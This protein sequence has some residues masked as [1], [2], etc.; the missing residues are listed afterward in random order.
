M[1]RPLFEIGEDVWLL[2]ATKEPRGAVVL[3]ILEVDHAQQHCHKTIGYDLTIPAG[4][5]FYGWCECMLRKRPPPESL[6]N[7]TEFIE[8]LRLMSEAT[9]GADHE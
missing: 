9:I 3:E 8:D 4:D 7:V 5:L 1:T 2:R 6:T